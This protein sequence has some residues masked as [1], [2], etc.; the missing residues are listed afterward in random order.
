M[1]KMQHGKGKIH[2][3]TQIQHSWHD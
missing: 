1:K 3:S 2:Q